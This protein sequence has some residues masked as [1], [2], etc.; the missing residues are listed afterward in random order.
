M[1]T[2]K[3]SAG[4]NVGFEPGVDGIRAAEGDLQENEI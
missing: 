4:G 3:L 1:N 2:N